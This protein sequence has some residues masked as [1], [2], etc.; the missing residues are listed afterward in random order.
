MTIST[1]RAAEKAAKDQN[2]LLNDEILDQKRKL[3]DSVTSGKNKEDKIGLLESQVHDR[4]VELECIR[5]SLNNKS[6]ESEE[7]LLKI[8]K[9]EQLVHELSTELSSKNG[10][11]RRLQKEIEDFQSM[12]QDLEEK[13]QHQNLKLQTQ[14]EVIIIGTDSNTFF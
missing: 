13:I 12:I 11:L 5:S 10:E 8:S 1:L 6:A 4:D 9:Q 7:N 2:N 3:T 14:E